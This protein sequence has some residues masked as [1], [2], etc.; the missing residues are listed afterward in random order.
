MIMLFT[1][2]HESGIG[3]F[4]DMPRAVIDVRYR[5]LSRPAVQAVRLP[6][7]TPKRTARFPLFDAR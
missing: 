7:L 6:V 5:G 4:S 1:A 3:H 2:L